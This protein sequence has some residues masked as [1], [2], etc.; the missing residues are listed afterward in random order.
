MDLDRRQFLKGLTYSSLV[1]P[2]ALRSLA[3]TSYAAEPLEGKKGLRIL[4]DRPMVAEANLTVLDEE[5][6]STEHMF[7]RN[8]G[9]V[10]TIATSKDI[11]DWRLVIDGEVSKPLQLSMH[12][13]KTRFKK[14][15]Y[16][17]VLECAGNGRAGYYPPGEGSQWTYGGVGCPLWEG[18]RLKDVLESAGVKTSAVFL[19]YYGHDIHPSGDLSKDPISRGVPIAKALDEMTLIA[20]GMN[21]KDLPA[22][23][24]YP[25][26]L[27]C[28]G[29]PASTSGKWLKRLWVRDRV[30]DGVKM[31]G[32]SYKVPRVPIAPGAD[33]DEKDMKIIEQMPVKSLITSPLCNTKISLAKHKSTVFRGFAWSGHGDIREVHVSKDFGQSWHKAHLKAPRNRFA[34]QRWECSLTFAERGYYEIWARATDSTG[35]MQPMVVPGWNPEGYLNNAMPRIAV[36]VSA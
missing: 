17:M 8:N 20:F 33:I 6:T 23:H 13:L 26:R 22:V 9:M 30:H 29:Y 24:G 2:L 1:A 35:T 25:A 7:V 14:Y 27:I 21:G 28:P 12:D 11:S 5:I 10:P 34:W 15:S 16:A 19:A 18:V 3:Q 32:K 4:N 31:T 36:H